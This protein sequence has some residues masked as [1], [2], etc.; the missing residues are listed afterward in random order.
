MSADDRSHYKNVY[1]LSIADLATDS[2]G[3][4][5]LA[6]ILTQFSGIHLILS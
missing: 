5:S 1:W 4:R 3:Q 2:D 6:R